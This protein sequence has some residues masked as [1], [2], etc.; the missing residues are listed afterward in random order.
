L[1][2]ETLGFSDAAVSHVITYEMMI[3]TEMF[4]TVCWLSH[5][6]SFTV[7]TCISK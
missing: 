2:V 3:A 6:V 7:S 5:L 1:R 4:K